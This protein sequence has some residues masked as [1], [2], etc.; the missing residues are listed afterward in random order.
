MRLKIIHHIGRAQI[1]IAILAYRPHSEPPHRVSVVPAFG[2]TVQNTYNNSVHSSTGKTPFYLAYSFHS[3][4]PDTPQFAS[5]INIP[6]AQ[7]RVLGLINSRLLYVHC[8]KRGKHM[9]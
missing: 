1:L 4:M 6:S 2:L 9:T 5:G 8:G 7:E 3:S